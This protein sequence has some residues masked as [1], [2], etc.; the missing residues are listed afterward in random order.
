MT[1]ELQAQYLERAFE[2]VRTEWPWVEMVFVWHLNAMAYAG[3]DSK[4][5][6][7][8]VTDVKAEPRPAYLAIQEFVARDLTEQVE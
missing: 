4:F 7:F 8:S 5:A 2:I 3:Q 1:E 6:G